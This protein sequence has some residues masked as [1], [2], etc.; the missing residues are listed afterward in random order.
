MFL[1]VNSILPVGTD[2]KVVSLFGYRSNGVPGIEIKG[3]PCAQNIVREKLV[4]L[5]KLYGVKVPIRKFHLCLDLPKEVSK[6]KKELIDDRYFD[7]PLLLLY[8]SLAEVIK[9]QSIEYCFALGKIQSDG[10]IEIPSVS[11]TYL[12]HLE[13]VIKE[14]TSTSITFISNGKDGYKGVRQI[15]ING[16]LNTIQ[17]AKSKA[18]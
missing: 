2:Y 14:K 18:L 15:P 17:A 16:I 7:L 13:N 5:S 8:W 4:Y 6:L 9:I 12:F 3:L 11:E 10:R 1:R